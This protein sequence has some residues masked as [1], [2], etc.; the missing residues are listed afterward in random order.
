MLA[1]E[2]QVAVELGLAFTLEATSSGTVT[3]SPP[4]TSVDSSSPPPAYANPAI[5]DIVFY[6]TP[7]EKVTLTAN[8]GPNSYFDGWQ[9][10]N[11]GRCEPPT[12]T[13]SGQIDGGSPGSCTITVQ[14]PDGI[15]RFS[16]DA[17]A[18]FLACPP[19]GTISPRLGAQRDRPGV[20]APGG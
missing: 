4:G 19:P 20:K 13:P 1:A 11:G 10:S 5:G 16:D 6:A 9:I 14:D 7:G 2:G 12:G 17:R 15:G 3:I 18:F 8:H